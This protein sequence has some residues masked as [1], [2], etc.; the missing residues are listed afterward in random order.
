MRLEG[1]EMCAAITQLASGINSTIKEHLTT[2][3]RIRYG[4]SVIFN[5]TCVY[6]G[7][8]GGF[9]RTTYVGNLTEKQNEILDVGLEALQEAIKM[10]KPRVN[11]YQVYMTTKKSI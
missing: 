2:T 9:E 1:S 7:Y 5:L 6:K 10:I 4:E 8:L 11:C 3:K